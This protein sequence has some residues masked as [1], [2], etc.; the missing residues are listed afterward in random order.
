VIDR[1]PEDR[2][3][4]ARSALAATFG[5]SPVMSLEPI[6]S[7]ASALSYRIEVA[8]RSYLLRLESSRRDEVRDPHRSYACMRLAAEAGIAPAVHHADAASGVAITQFVSQR[9]LADYAGGGQALRRDLGALVARLQAIPAFPP[10]L[11]YPAVIGRL[12]FWLFESG[13]YAPGLLAPH[14]QRFERIRE[15]LPW[16]STSLVS[17]HNDLNPH[18]ILFDGDRLWLID[19]ETAYGN[20]PLVDVATLM[21][22]FARVPGQEIDLLQSCL[23][24]ELDRRQRARLVLI[25]LLVRLFYG[26][27]ASLNAVHAGK[28]A[29]PESDLVA[30][31][32][33]QFVALVDQKGLG[34]GSPEGQRLVGKM[35]FAGFM[36]DT[37]TPEFEEALAVVRQG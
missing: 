10:V 26:C 14:R 28:P 15:A 30:P 19:W 8:G 13:M 7:G 11:P 16:D 23:G 35:A 37:A 24:R 20:D 18:N 3:E 9:P 27:A 6:A 21:L 2:R 29:V 34:A 17:G 31:T 25:R 36:A 1:I 32:H 22:F 33:E 5:R 4:R 12:L